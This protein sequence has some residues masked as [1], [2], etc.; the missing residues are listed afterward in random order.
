MKIL[1]LVMIVGSQFQLQPR[2]LL[3][4][5]LDTLITIELLTKNAKERPTIKQVLDDPWITS[6][7]KE[8]KVLREKAQPHQL[9]QMYSLTKPNSLKIYDEVD[10]VS[11][12]KK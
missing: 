1:H 9:F 8:V 2:N 11:N 7:C 3:K 6:Y 10:K 5:S 12:E 4:V